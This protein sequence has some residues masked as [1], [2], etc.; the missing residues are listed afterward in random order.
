MIGTTGF[1]AAGL[2]RIRV[3][4]ARIP[5]LMSPNMSVGVNLVFRLLEIAARALQDSADIEVIEAHH[6]NKI[7]AP[8]GT[9]L[10]MG[11]I[12]AQATGRNLADVAVYGR[13][14]LSGVRDRSTIGFETI[15][16]GDIVGDH[17]VMFA[18]AGERIEITHRAHTRANF[19]EGALRGARFLATARPGLHAMRDVLGL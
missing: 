13:Q 15:R 1:D 3:A 9:A 8:S 18:T 17:T 12:L 6:R 7:D 16:A 19:A 4:S 2:E 14:G 5:V 11:E 10:R